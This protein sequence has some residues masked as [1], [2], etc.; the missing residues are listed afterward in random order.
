MVYNFSSWHPC[1]PSSLQQ[2][3]CPYTACRL[4]C[5]H[6]LHQKHCPYTAC[7]LLCKHSLQQKHCPY[8]ACCLFCKHSLQRKHRPHSI[9]LTCIIIRYCKAKHGKASHQHGGMPSARP[10]EPS[11]RRDASCTASCHHHHG[12]PA[13]HTFIWAMLS[14]VSE[15]QPNA[16]DR[17]LPYICASSS[18]NLGS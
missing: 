10:S 8:T 2:K 12:T 14:S 16:G 3:H 9:H 4:L 11:A 7:R 6:S 15:M 5:K 13:I 18:K 1:H 17:N